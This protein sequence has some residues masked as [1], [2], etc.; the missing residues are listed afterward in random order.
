MSK[1]GKDKH[2][3][4]CEKELKGEYYHAGNNGTPFCSKECAYE[5]FDGFYKESEVEK[6]LVKRKK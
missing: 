1:L 3:Q 2:C 4:N 5:A 6:T